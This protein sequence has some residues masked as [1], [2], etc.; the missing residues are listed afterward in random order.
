MVICPE[1]GSKNTC[2]GEKTKGNPRN[3]ALIGDWDGWYPFRRKANHSCGAI[4]VSVLN[5]SKK[6]RCCTDEVYVVDFVPCYKGPNKRTCALD[7]F[8][9]PLVRDLEDSFMQG[10]KVKYATDVIGGCSSAVETVVHCL[11]LLWTGNYPAQCEVGKF[12]NCGIF[13]QLKTYLRGTNIGNRSTYYIANNR[14]RIRF[15]VQ[16]RTSYVAN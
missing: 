10:T 14:H 3:I 5:L 4:E 2:K 9:E 15:P 7:P 1:C 16:P 11:L 13:P 6:D 12:I 8:L